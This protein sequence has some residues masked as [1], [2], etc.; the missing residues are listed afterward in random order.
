MG[1]WPR[2]RWEEFEWALAAFFESLGLSSIDQAIRIG[3]KGSF[4]LIRGSES[5][6]VGGPFEGDVNA[7]ARA[8]SLPWGVMRGKLEGEGN[9]FGTETEGVA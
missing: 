8:C 9:G 2:P 3:L 4:S 6:Q 1:R 5:V 7:G